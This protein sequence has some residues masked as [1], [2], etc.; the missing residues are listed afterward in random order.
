V[1]IKTVY[2]ILFER[3][4]EGEKELKTKAKEL[5]QKHLKNSV[6]FREEPK[7]TLIP[8]Y[9]PKQYTSPHA[10]NPSQKS[11]WYNPSLVRSSSRQP[12][13]A[14]SDYYD[15]F[16]RHEFRAPLQG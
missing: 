4:R 6:V 12:S 2:T 13:Y 14:S 1:S 5:L 8:L 11:E 15:R 16:I 7:N 9:V 10:W 3:E